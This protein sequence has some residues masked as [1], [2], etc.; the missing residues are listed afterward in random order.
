MKETLIVD[1][2]EFDDD[3]EKG[4]ELK[5]DLNEESPKNYF[6]I[7]SDIEEILKDKEKMSQLLLVVREENHW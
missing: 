3:T 7:I 6:K 1:R 2:K 5:D 4:N